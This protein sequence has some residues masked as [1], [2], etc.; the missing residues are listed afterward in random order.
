MSLL[1]RAPSLSDEDPILMISFNIT[2]LHKGL[3][4]KDSKHSPL[5]VATCEFG[6][7]TIQPITAVKI[8]HAM[9]QLSLYLPWQPW[10]PCVPDG[11]VKRWK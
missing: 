8:T 5:L 10:K 4:I 6:G 2:Y 7:D 9:L 1:I 11:V 3:N